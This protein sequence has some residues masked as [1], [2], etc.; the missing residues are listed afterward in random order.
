MSDQHS[1]KQKEFVLSCSQSLCHTLIFTDFFEYIW[2][3]E[4]LSFSKKLKNKN[5]NN[6]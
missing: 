3:K 6:K 5:T 4:N 1:S 2:T